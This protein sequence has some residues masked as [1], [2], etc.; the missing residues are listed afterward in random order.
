MLANTA[1]PTVQPIAAPV[2]FLPGTLCDERIWQPVW[3]AM[4]IQQ[5]AYVP[6]QWAESM[7]H[8]LAL[9]ADRINSFEEPVHLIGFSMGGYVAALSA[10]DKANAENIASITLVAYNPYG[11]TDVE[12]NARLQMLK[13]IKQKKLKGLDNQ[14]LAQYFTSEELTQP[15]L[16]Q[17]ILDMEADLGNSVLYA[18]MNSTTPRQDLAKQLSKLSIKQH[19]LSA[20]YDK[21]APALSIQKYCQQTKQAT[22]THYENTGH[23]LP[24]TRTFELAKDL[25]NFILEHN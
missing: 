5:R 18:H 16:V 7:E 14:R 25:G 21:I 1:S 23:I 17:P 10:L 4:N 15:E 20:Q 11:L 8:M 13:S 2:I 19:W 6:L 12:T 3:Q 22:L 24:L 9:S